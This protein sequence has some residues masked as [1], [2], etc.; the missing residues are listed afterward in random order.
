MSYDTRIRNAIIAVK[1]NTD[2]IYI[3]I[4]DGKIQGTRPD[5]FYMIYRPGKVLAIGLRQDGKSTFIKIKEGEEHSLDLDIT[6]F[7]IVQ[8]EE[9]IFTL[10]YAPD[11]AMFTEPLIAGNDGELSILM[12]FIKRFFRLP[13]NFRS[14]PKETQEE[15]DYGE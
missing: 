1:Y 5:E 7:I 2:I 9:G 14:L 11:D 4:A 6:A 15:D 3:R 12:K 8:H 10:F 13:S